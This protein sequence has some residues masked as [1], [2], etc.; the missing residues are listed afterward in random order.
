MDAQQSARGCPDRDVWQRFLLGLVSDEDAV[1]LEDHLDGCPACLETLHSLEGTAPLGVGPARG[2]AIDKRL[3]PDALGKGESSTPSSD[4]VTLLSDDG[5]D[6]AT[7]PPAPAEPDRLG[8]YRVLGVVGTGGMGVVFRALDTRLGRSVAVK[9][10][11]ENHA[12]RS[13]LV[14][15]F[16]EEAQIAGQLQHPGITPV[17]ELGQDSSQRPYFSMK[18]VKGQTLAKLLGERSG[19]GEDLPRFLGIFEQVCQAMAY[20]HSKGVIHRDLKPSN[21]MVGAFGEVQVMD[22]GLAK[23]LGERRGSSPPCGPDLRDQPGGSPALTQAGSVMGTPAY[24]APEQARGEVDRVDERADVFGLGAILCEV[25]TGQP[26]FPGKTH[27]AMR[28]AQKADLAGAFARLDGCVADAE[29]V[30]LARRCLAAEPAARPGDAATVAEAITEHQ[31]SVAQRLRRAELER[32]Q[33]QVKAAEERK[34]RRLT[35]ALAGSVLFTVLLGSGVW[36]WLAE[37]DRA[38][39]QKQARGREEI[40]RVLNEATRL[41]AG[42]TGPWA[43]QARAQARGQVQRALALLEHTPDADAHERAS[44]MLAEMDAQERDRRLLDRLEAARLAATDIDLDRGRF[45][46]EH[47][48]PLYREALTEYGWSVGK[49]DVKRLA[50]E[51]AGR[52]REVREAVVA[53]LDDWVVLAPLVKEPQREWLRRLVEQVDPA[54]WTSQV[55][56]ASHLARGERRA[57]LEKLARQANEK[58]LPP[59]ALALLAKRL[60][61]EG[62]RPSAM[63]LRRRARQQYPG[64]YWLN[65]DLGRALLVA[66]Q[67]EAVRYLTVAVA[68]RPDSAGAHLDLGLALK[69]A[70]K[71]DEAIACYHKAI[72]LNPRASFPHNNLGLALKAQEKVEEAIACYRQ[73]IALDPRYATPHINLGNALLGTGKVDEAIECYRKA[74]ELNP[75]SSTGHNN[76]GKALKEKGKVDQAIACFLEAIKVD[77]RHVNAHYNLGVALRDRGKVDE[78]IPCFQKAIELD[79]RHAQAHNNLGIALKGKGR[80]DEAIICYRKAIALD[81][82]HANAHYNLGTALNDSRRVDEAIV[83]FQKAI[84]LDPRHGQAH[85]NLGTALKARGKVREAIACYRKAIAIDPGN[86][87]AHFNLGNTLLG[88]GKLDEAIPCLHKAV[89]LRPRSVSAH[90]ALGLALL[91]Q[92]QFTQAEASTRR[93][94]ALLPPGH[95]LLPRV[96]R[97]LSECQRLQGLD[98]KLRDVQAG[99]AKPASV[100]EQFQ[101]AQL[102]L[103]TRR[104]GWG[105]RLYAEAFG[106][107][108]KLAD[109]L[110]AM[111]H[112]NAARCAVQASYARG[113]DGDQPDD[114]E[115]TRLRRQALDWLRASLVAWT[116]HLGSGAA[117]DRALLARTLRHWRDD[118]DLSGVRDR[119]ALANLPEAE[120]TEWQKLWSDV[121]R[122]LRQ[123]GSPK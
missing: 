31:R 96:S 109:N 62:A 70:G 10:L 15:R 44:A 12:A 28:L 11:R 83:C 113:K 38:E 22:W 19:P 54:G 85:N 123:T 93:A 106:A 6:L 104:F 13:E 63:A 116:R 42:A 52:P 102:C 7:P 101:F 80:I 108:A 64:D 50:G 87:V 53:A 66:R 34:R 20:A 90:G 79:P 77:P 33:A 32:A 82:R 72:E 47:A 122:S 69:Q 45:A 105:A 60:A 2:E 14:Q 43:S 112:Y 97:Q 119:E 115:R 86:G 98:G 59:A 67:E 35:L 57:A 92:G 56:L 111:H 27:Q 24:M 89:E 26:P 1:P 46:Q 61:G 17:Y 65:H 40:A 78:A 5:N 55:R 73:A 23:R 114:S 36:V 117:G 88:Q 21:V 49:D 37:Q 16:V 74:T 58:E 118:A 30:V 99:K 9:E 76:L 8:P 18:L 75:R 81:P 120:R 95:P 71:V 84:E 110:Q 3:I 4:S 107:E 91:Q 41:Q 103:T 51:L 121:A 48:I 94:L 25:L 100:A 29:L 68:L 39:A